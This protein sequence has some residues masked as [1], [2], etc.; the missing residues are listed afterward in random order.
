[1]NAAIL[2]QSALHNILTSPWLLL[3]VIALSF[4]WQLGAVPL[5][6]L[7]EGAFTEATRE[8]LDSGNFITPHKDGAPRYDKP[9]LI[10]WLQAASTQLFGFNEFALRLPSA[11]AA[12]IWVLALWGFI[13][14]QIDAPTATVAG[15]TLA[16]ALQVSLI[17]KAAVA[18]AVLNLF[19]ALTFFELYRY[20]TAPAVK[21]QRR[22]LYRAYLWMGLGFLTKGPIAVF[23]P[24]LVSFLFALTEIRW[25]LRSWQQ[26][27]FEKK[28]LAGLKQP[29]HRWLTAAFSP[30][31]WL[32]FLLITVPWHLAI[33]FDD[34]MGFF[35]SFFLHH[36]AGRFTAVMHGHAGFPGYYV[37]VLPLILLPFSGWLLNLWRNY[38]SAWC[39]SFERFLWLWFISVLLFF[40]FSAT[41]LPHYLLYGATPL[42]ILMA[43]YREQLTQRS[44]AVLPPLLFMAFLVAVPLIVDLVLHI[45]HGIATSPSA[46]VRA[47]WEL[48]PQIAGVLI[49]AQQAFDLIYGVVALIGLALIIWFWRGLTIPLWQRLIFIGVIQTLVV[50]GV[51]VP[52]LFTALQTPVKEAALIAKQ[53]TAP[54]VIYRTSAPSFSVYRGAITPQ[55]PPQSGDLVFLRLDKLAALQRDYPELTPRLIYQ[56]GAVALLSMSAVNVHQEVVP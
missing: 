7:D 56:R 38:R 21:K 31:G 29:L 27:P 40:S 9:I 16:L 34:G 32:I 1:M 46:E 50:Y 22:S 37:I 11:I 26:L 8:M 53:V 43:K 18:D 51:V 30:L 4:F 28:E 47:M 35:E 5:Y 33:Y 23:F 20:F 24:V 3:L 19:L 17:G 42:F 36:N 13:R 49:A 45:A 54:T 14:K 48:K 10:Y 25:P 12:S 39:D 2:K 41:Q 6:D 52:R 44:L 55:R 15:L